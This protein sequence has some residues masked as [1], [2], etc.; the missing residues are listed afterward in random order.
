MQAPTHAR[1]RMVMSSINVALEEGGGGGG[2]RG[3][4]DATSVA[5]GGGGGA[6]TLQTVT[7]SVYVWTWA[8]VRRVELPGSTAAPAARAATS[9][10]AR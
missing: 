2:S 7:G 5:G 6:T 9:W 3:G 1:I 4:G 10:S 8:A